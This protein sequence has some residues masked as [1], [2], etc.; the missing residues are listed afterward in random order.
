MDDKKIIRISTLTDQE[1]THIGLAQIIHSDEEMTV[2]SQSYDSNSCLVDL[3]EK[4]P[5]VL[6]LDLNSMRESLSEFSKLARTKLPHLKII[7][8]TEHPSDT[9]IDMMMASGLQGLL[10]K[11]ESGGGILK[12]IKGICLAGH[13]YVSQSLKSRLVPVAKF[14]GATS[15][16]EPQS[17]ATATSRKGLLSPREM[18]V[19]GSVALGLSAKQIGSKFNI[20]AKTVERHKSNIMSKLE[21]HSQVDLTRY[22]IREGIISV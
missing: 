2:V 1:I 12:A 4:N 6:I 22:A 9:Q 16:S 8:L 21:I 10:S 18:E 3:S 20:S 5:D 19:L 11:R 15:E 14:M 17:S 7:A 13:N